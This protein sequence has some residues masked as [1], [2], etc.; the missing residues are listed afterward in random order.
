VSVNIASRPLSDRVVLLCLVDLEL[1]GATPAHAGRVV[2]A[3]RTDVDA[4]EA[5]TLGRLSEAEVSRALNRLNADGLAEV[6]MAD[7]GDRSPSGKG[8]PE[9]APAV[10][11]DTVLDG[12]ADD[13][14]VGSLAGR[15]GEGR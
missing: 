1:S 2:R 9:Y 6:E 13:D 4:V 14:Q 10:G 8:R 5:E 15:V 12:L 11:P 7:P 3:T